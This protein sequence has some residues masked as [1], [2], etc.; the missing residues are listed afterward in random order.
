MPLNAYNLKT[1]G[2]AAGDGQYVT[3][4]LS[5]AAGTKIL[6]STSNL[7]VPG[8]AGVG[9]Y[10][11]VDGPNPFITIIDTY[12]SATQIVLHDAAPSPGLSSQ[13]VG[14]AWGTNDSNAF[15]AFNT[16]CK[17]AVG[18][19]TLTIP[20]GVYMDIPLGGPNDSRWNRFISQVKV[21]G[22]GNPMIAGALLLGSLT[23]PGTNGGWFS[24]RLTHVK[25][26]DTSL[27]LLNPADAFKF[28]PGVVRNTASDGTVY[29][30]G[31]I[32][33]LTGI[34]TEGFGDPTPQFR[35][36]VT[37]TSVNDGTG[38]ISIASPVT[39]EYLSTWPA[40]VPGSAFTVDEGGPA[41]LYMWDN[42][43]NANCEFVNIRFWSP[44]GSINCELR[45]VTFTNCAWVQNFSGVGGF[46][47]AT[48]ESWTLNNTTFTGKTEV[49]KNIHQLNVLNSTGHR[50]WLQ[51]AACENMLID[52]CTVDQVEGSAR[53]TVMN[54][55]TVT[56]LILGP[57]AN[58]S[59]NSFKATNCSFGSIGIEFKEQ[60][61]P[62]GTT[63]YSISGGRITKS[64]SIGFVPTRWAIPGQRVIIQGQQDA[65]AAFG[66]L[67]VSGD[68][69]SND[70]NTMALLH[71]DGTN[72]S[73]VI[74]D[75]NA[76]GTANTW[77]AHGSAAISTAAFKFN[78][79]SLLLNG[80]TDYVD[81]PN[82]SDFALTGDFTAECWFNLQGGD[83]STQTLFAQT[84]ST[85]TAGNTSIVLQRNSS[86]VLVAQAFGSVTT[87]LTGTTVLKVATN[88]GWHHVAFVRTTNSWILFLDGIAETSLFQVN[89]INT[90]THNFVIGRLGEDATQFFNGYIDEFRLSVGIARWGDSFVPRNFPYG[91][92]RGQPW[93]PATHTFID[94]DLT[95]GWP[96]VPLGSGTDMFL[97]THPAPI[98]TFVNC[99]G[100]ADAIDFSNPLAQGKPLYS[101]TKRTYASTA[102]GTILYLN[103]STA[104]D[105]A[106]IWGKIVT[107][108][109]TVGPAFTTAGA[110]VMN[111]FSRFTTPA[112]DP[113][114]GA[115]TMWAPVIDLK[116]PGIRIM[117][118]TSIT[119]SVGIDSLGSPPGAIFF[120]GRIGPF[121]NIAGNP[122]TVTPGD[123]GVVTIEMQTDQGFPSIIIATPTAPPPQ[124]GNRGHIHFQSGWVSGR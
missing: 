110:F 1:D 99:T 93:D 109:V 35:E 72:G 34:D 22:I 79:A 71:F 123:P 29:T 58:G 91:D 112:V 42:A 48:C 13:L 15:I 8:D 23:F 77:T 7:F 51:T 73:I 57:V 96:T 47:P 83:N 104:T 118:A 106:E 85:F 102:S 44:S 103:S 10:I 116:T 17:G 120:S 60:L 33:N 78:G 101:Y 75:V 54:N 84:D 100:C 87:T 43:W 9:K 53:F 12:N 26:G 6:N 95:S 55:S 94:T 89:T 62:I 86:N 45:F 40:Y 59:A 25:P 2:L 36:F 27:Q 30:T 67:A 74:T 64:V 68:G 52:T 111:L 61:L 105:F 39:Y 24:A 80:S 117:K 97:T 69:T 63:G 4:I 14:L 115:F 28:H 113:L 21:V 92:V 5:I 41:T 46:F 107:V 90:S 18:L 3:D 121:T 81:T 114:T 56:T 20:A 119:G 124:R 31:T 16:A 49:D 122:V 98:A 19:V 32:G 88:P 66:I 70:A 38:V 76:G 11:V 50:W 65:E 37:I 82:N 108:T